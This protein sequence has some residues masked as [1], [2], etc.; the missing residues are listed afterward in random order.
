M[1]LGP[2]VADGAREEGMPVRIGAEEPGLRV[3]GG[4]VSTCTRFSF[5]G[6]QGAGED[7]K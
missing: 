7:R 5:T 2:G 3:E 6:G 1:E 4:R